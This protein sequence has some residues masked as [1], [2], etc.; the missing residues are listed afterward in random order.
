M[1]FKKHTRQYDVV[2]YGAT[3]YTGLRTSE[4][5]A[6]HF[7]TGTKWAVAG[8][9]AQKLEDVVKTCQDL[10]PDRKPPQVE[11]CSLNDKDLAALAKKAFIIIATVG[12]YG[13]YGEHMFKACAEAGT[14][15][16][17]CTGEAVWHAAMIKKYEKLAK[18]SGACMFPQSAV[19]SAPSDLVTFSLASLIKSE[20][21][22]PVGDVVVSLHEMRS[23][24]SGGTL[25]TVIS[26][27][28]TFS[29]KQVAASHLPYALS[30]IPN[31]KSAPKASIQSK[32]TGAQYVPNLG[33][34]TTSLTGGTDTAVV[35]R[36]WGLLQQEPVL[37]KLGPYGPNFTYRE[38]MKT[39]NIVTAITMHYSLLIGGVLLAFCSP[40]RNLLR[41]FVFQP[42]QGPSREDSANDYIEFRGVGTPDLHP[43][44]GKQA[45]CRA[46]FHGSMYMLTAA[47][48]SGAVRTLL[49]DDIG[50]DGGIYTPACLGQGYID[51]LDEYGF[52]I[53]TKIIEN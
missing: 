7:P 15:Y 8:R 12:P 45:L 1:P 31:S 3:G 27:F 42:G 29:F 35:H 30:P 49:E 11:V 39:R 52:K 9:S 4:F 20:L 32:L 16:F 36:T 14:H 53:E 18:A 47:F 19:E 37:Q 5:I 50:L 41:R 17:D 2:V 6:S 26:L 46:W 43:T 44:T 48:L 25:A 23:A 21:S 38:F 10:N 33:L 22:A 24:P 13:K 40:F 28:E 34:Q 51:R